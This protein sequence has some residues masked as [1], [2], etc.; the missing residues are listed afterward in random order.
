MSDT[1]TL[2]L[3]GRYHERLCVLAG[4]RMD[5]SPDDLDAADA[6]SRA[7]LKRVGAG[8]QAHIPVT[9][10]QAATI[11]GWLDIAF[12][13]KATAQ[14]RDLLRNFAEGDR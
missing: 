1:A 4:E 10:A 3:P 11:A 12:P 5:N 2:R 7:R 13:G 6:V 14:V 9:R 8:Y